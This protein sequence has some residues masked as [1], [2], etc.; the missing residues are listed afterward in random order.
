MHSMYVIFY[1]SSLKGNGGM[2]LFVP[3]IRWLTWGFN[4]ISH[5]M[6]SL[7]KDA[8]IIGFDDSFDWHVVDPVSHP[9]SVVE[10][11]LDKQTKS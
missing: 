4:L 9:M 6:L 8:V 10:S 11:F 5:L 2:H 1:I 3:I 7:D